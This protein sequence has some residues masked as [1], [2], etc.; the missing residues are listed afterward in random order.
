MKARAALFLLTA[1]ALSACSYTR[2]D[3]DLSPEEDA[4]M[5]GALLLSG[6]SEAHLLATSPHRPAGGSPPKGVSATLTGDGW[7][8]AYAD[9]VDLKRCNVDLPQKWRPALCL[10]AKLPQPIRAGVE[11]AIEGA[12]HKGGFRGRTTVPRPPVALALDTQRVEVDSS[13]SGNSVAAELEVRFDA[14]PEVGAVAIDIRNAIQLK[15][16]GSSRAGWILAVTPPALDIRADSQRVKVWGRW[17]RPGGRFEAYLIGY[18][19]NYSRFVVDSREANV[20]YKPWPSFGIEGDE[21]VYGYF[22]AAALSLKA[23]LV[24]VD[25]K[26]Q[27]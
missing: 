21:G 7:K 26:S 2:P 8:A 1:A 5:I 25:V 9:P 10:R 12:T 19:T 3:E 23:I 17:Q 16:D 15:S 18:E 22:G 4:V 13:D 14:P 6:Q 24:V 20:L 27:P 11:Y